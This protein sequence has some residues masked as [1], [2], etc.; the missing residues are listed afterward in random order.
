M[1]IIQ[2]GVIIEGGTGPYLNAGVQSMA[3]T[4]CSD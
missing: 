3:L 1:G 4:K 2:G